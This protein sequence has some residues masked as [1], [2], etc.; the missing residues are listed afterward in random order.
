MVR[1]L[2]SALLVLAPVQEAPRHDSVPPTLPALRTGV[3]IFSK[4]NGYRHAD[5]I[6]HS[7]AVLGE[8]ARAAGQR[9]VAT[10]N[11]AVFS[12]DGLARFRIVVLD[13]SSG[14]VWSEP[15][16]AAFRRWI[17]RGGRVLALH[18]AGGDPSYAWDWYPRELIRAQFVG[19]PGQADQFQAGVFRVEAPRHPVMR[20]VRL[21]WRPVDEW[22]SFAAS[23]RGRVEVLASIDPASYRAAPGQTMADHPVVWT[24]RIGEGRVVYSALG[25]RPQAY[26]DPNYRRIL[27]NALRW[28]AR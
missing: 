2:L 21:P 17:E 23:P 1:L 27:A 5:Q 13:N 7:V 6:P 14:D 22:Y 19:H 9:S 11:G 25:H 10:E 24:H 28:L 4:T 3:L 16:R 26:D 15:Q 20:G 8:L 12:D 18:A